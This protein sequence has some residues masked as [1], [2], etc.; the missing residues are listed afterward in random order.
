MRERERERKERKKNEKVE[1]KKEG[2][3][4][5]LLT[6]HK[7]PRTKFFFSLLLTPVLHSLSVN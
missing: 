3:E 1:T 7:S 5:R 6:T 2:E 4:R